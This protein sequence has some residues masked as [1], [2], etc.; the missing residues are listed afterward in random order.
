MKDLPEQLWK[1]PG[2]AVE[3]IEGFHAHQRRQGDWDQHE[4]LIDFPEPKVPAVEKHSE[5]NSDHSGSDDTDKGDE[6]AAS[7]SFA[8]N[9]AVVEERSV[10]RE[11][12]LTRCD[13]ALKRRDQR[14][15]NV[16]PQHKRQ[17]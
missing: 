8:L 3:K 1:R 6:E 12:A 13:A 17:Q 14:A 16:A 9:A 10:F 5:K 7:K 15:D 4:C 11:C 2:F